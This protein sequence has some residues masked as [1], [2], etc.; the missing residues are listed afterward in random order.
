V[1][2]DFYEFPQDY[3]VQCNTIWAMTDFT[4]A[5]GATRIVPGSHKLPL[6]LNF[7]TEDT[8]PVVMNRGDMM[9]YSGKLY[10]GAG[11][12]TTKDLVRKGINITYAVGWVRQEENQ[13]LACP[14]EVARSLPDELLAV[15]GY[16]LGANAVGYWRDTEDPLS[17]VRSM[18][19]EQFV[20][21]D[22][23][24]KSVRE[25]GST[26][27][28]NTNRAADYLAEIEALEKDASAS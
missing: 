10:H 4:E 1:L 3:H 25:A 11:A 22:T 17:A 2:W 28:Y 19:Y 26:S 12:N 20:Y 8:V 27:G 13:Y 5:N 6:G 18:P 24:R 23:V 15:M 7:K 21:V 9:V 16:S 14:P